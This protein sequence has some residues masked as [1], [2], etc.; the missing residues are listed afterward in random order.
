[1]KASASPNQ[2]PAVGAIG[3]GTPSKKSERRRLAV[4]LCD[5]LLL[6]SL[7]LGSVLILSNQIVFAQEN[8]APPKKLPAADKIIEN[9]LRATGGKKRVAAIKDATYDWT[10]QL[11]GSSIGTARTQRKPPSAERWELTF[12]NGQIISASSASSAWETGLDG[13]MHT[14]IGPEGAVAKLQA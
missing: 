14:L 6:I 12:G 8:S 1:M 10:I 2:L 7:I 3:V 11:K 9:Y 5:Y 4:F 13:R